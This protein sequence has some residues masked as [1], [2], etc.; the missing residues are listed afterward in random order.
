MTAP[1]VKP[2]KIQPNMF[3]IKRSTRATP[4]LL[5]GI[6][7]TRMTRVKAALKLI[8]LKL[9]QIRL[10]EADLGVLRER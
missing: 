6:L 8:W 2:L 10:V 5:Q 7:P 1:M 4:Q 9:A 3:S